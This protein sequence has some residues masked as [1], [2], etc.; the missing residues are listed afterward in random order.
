MAAN[1]QHPLWAEVEFEFFDTEEP[2]K[3]FKNMACIPAAPFFQLVSPG[4]ER[5]MIPLGIVKQLNLRPS[6]VAQPPLAAVP[7]ASN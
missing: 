5:I 6:L 3:I 2:N 1:E 4:G 7:P